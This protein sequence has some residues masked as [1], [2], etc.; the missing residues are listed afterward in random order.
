MP[1]ATITATLCSSQAAG[2]YLSDRSGLIWSRGSTFPRCGLMD[3]AACD[4]AGGLAGN[5]QYKTWG[6]VVN[7]GVQ[8]RWS[9][10]VKCRKTTARLWAFRSSPISK[11]EETR[12]LPPPWAAARRGSRPTAVT[13]RTAA[14]RPTRSG[15]P[16]HPPPGKTPVMPPPVTPAEPGPA[17]CAWSQWVGGPPRLHAGLAWRE[18]GKLRH[19]HCLQMDRCRVYE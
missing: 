1:S 4:R 6:W 10:E 8:T 14:A 13:L 5:G 3:R 12:S 17:A 11:P 9:G 7:P 15:C 19:L 18:Q 2:R 16:A